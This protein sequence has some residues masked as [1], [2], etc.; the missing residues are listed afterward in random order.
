VTDLVK[1]PE[2]KVVTSAEEVIIIRLPKATPMYANAEYPRLLRIYKDHLQ[3]SSETMD[4]FGNI[5]RK[6]RNLYYNDFILMN[7]TLKR[8]QHP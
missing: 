4:T 8:I 6:R 1:K 7:E 2:F 5:K 3:L